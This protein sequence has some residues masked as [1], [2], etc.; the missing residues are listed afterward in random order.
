LEWH[1]LWSKTLG[2]V[3]YKLKKIAL[4]DL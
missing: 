2:V 1:N 3:D 4:L